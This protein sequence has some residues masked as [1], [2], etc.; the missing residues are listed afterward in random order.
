MDRQSQRRAQQRADRIVAFRA[1]LDEL[2]R[3]QGLTLTAEQHAQLQAHHERLL[4][5]LNDRFGVDVSESARRVSWGMR[6]ATFLGGVAFFTALVLFLQRIWGVMPSAAQA[7]VLV[8]FPLLLLAAAEVAFRRQAALYYT[9]LLALAAGVAFVMGLTFL[10]GIFNA[11]P[12][13]HALLAWAAVGLLL[14]YAYGLRL[15]LAAGLVL[16][17]AYTASLWVAAGG[18][19]WA[20]FM[21]RAGGLIPAAVLCYAVPSFRAHR[22]PHGFD[23]VYRLC[24]A[25]VALLA[26]LILSKRGDLCCSGLPGRLVETVYQLMGMAGSVAVVL[27]GLR[28]GRGGLVNLGAAAFVVFLFVRLHAW[29]WAWMPRYL[30][31]L[32]LGLIAVALLLVFRRTRTRLAERGE[33]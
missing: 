12:S 2:E 18:G 19:Y 11:A 15:P 24:G 10:G 5:A 7:G 25:A 22:D 33:R 29:W 17:C 20:S 1:E 13:P 21:E 26:L 30:F 8:A 23:F 32:L 27:H 6:L 4:A 9:A 16:F 3:E 14:A 31:F 28:L